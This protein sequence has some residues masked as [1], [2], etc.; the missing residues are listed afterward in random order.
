VIEC[1]K[2]WTFVGGKRNKQWLWLAFDRDTRFI[3][4]A[5]ITD[6]GISGA[7]GLW[8]NMPSHYRDKAHCYTDY[9][10]AYQAVIPSDQHDAVGKHTGLTNHIERFNL[11]M[12]QRIS[13]P[14]RLT[15]LMWI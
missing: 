6:R 14:D 9:W 13:R 12:R 10:E 8:A 1:D 5:H 4:A 11:T 2:I 15:K 7:Q 3:I